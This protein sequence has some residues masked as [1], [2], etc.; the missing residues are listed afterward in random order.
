ME[1]ITPSLWGYF[2]DWKECCVISIHHWD[3]T[4]IQQIA[5]H[6]SVIGGGN[7]NEEAEG[8]KVKKMCLLSQDYNRQKSALNKCLLTPTPG[9]LSKILLA[10]NGNLWKTWMLE[11]SVDTINGSAGIKIIIFLGCREGCNSTTWCFTG[12]DGNWLK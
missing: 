7:Q 5:A 12:T 6:S 11:K 8:W 2:K 3:E 4:V 10:Y 9:F 1:I